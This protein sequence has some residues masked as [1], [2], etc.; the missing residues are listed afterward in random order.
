MT[1]LTDLLKL[2]VVERLELIDAL[3]ESVEADAADIPVPDELRAELEKREAEDEAD[4]SSAMAW[5][6]FRK[7]LQ[8][9]AK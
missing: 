9:R 2:P 6:D 4:P 7:E 1:N 3:W 8:P 5:D